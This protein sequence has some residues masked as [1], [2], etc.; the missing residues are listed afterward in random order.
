MKIDSIKPISYNSRTTVKTRRV[1]DCVQFRAKLNINKPV[2]AGITISSIFAGIIGFITGAQ[3]QEKSETEKFIK[4]RDK[5]TKKLEPRKKRFNEAKWKLN[6]DPNQSVQFLYIMANRDLIKLHRNKSMYRKFADIDIQQLSQHDANQLKMILNSFDDKLKVEELKSVINSKVYSANNKYNEYVLVVDGRQYTQI[7]LFNLLQTEK[8]PDIRKKACETLLKRG[9]RIT[10]DLIEIVKARNN[11][12]HAKGYD[13][14]YEYV[15]K[16]TYNTDPEYIDKLMEDVYSKIQPK[17]VAIHERRDKRLKEFFGVEKLERYHYGLLSDS[18]P[19]RL[20]D[21]ILKNES[22]ENISKKTYAGMGYDIDKFITDG[23]LTM[24]LYPR[25]NKNPGTFC[26]EVEPGKDVRILANITDC[27]RSL[28]SLNHEL[29]HCIY[30]LGISQDLPF[31]DRK[32]SSAALTEAI[33][34]MMGDI[35]K[36]ENILKGIVPDYILKGYKD[37]LK[38]DA[39]ENLVRELLIMTFEREIYKNPNQNPAELWAKL[40]EKY[41]DISAPADNEWADMP[42]YLNYPGY[43]QNYFRAT[44]MK[45]QIYNHL[46]EVLGNITENKKTAEYMNKNIFSAGASVNEYDL[47]RQ[48]TGKELGTE[49]FVK[50]L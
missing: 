13:N 49:D 45:A 39:V 6:T 34:L 19:T 25:K 32:P 18:D 21:E 48:L 10:K 31:L 40:R 22:I 12:A 47:I 4:L 36:K 2:Y 29:G 7:E 15:L 42:H 50:G 9:N 11:Y 35:K 37:S 30:S 23:K 38:R 24:D 3:K 1:Q 14:Y 26:S 33:A 20:T 8:N 44:L 43:Y 41:L 5:Y 17:A 27:S 28:E 16:E 46:H